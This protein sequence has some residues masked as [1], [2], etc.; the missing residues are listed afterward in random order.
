[1]HDILLF[2][3]NNDNITVSSKIL[4]PPDFRL[5]T[6]SFSESSKMI[7]RNT[8]LIILDMCDV[9]V[10]E[11]PFYRDL[12]NKISRLKKPAIVILN[13]KQSEMIPFIAADLC[14]GS[15]D[16]IFQ[17]QL[18]KELVPRIK[19]VLSRVYDLKENDKTIS[20]DGLVINP[21][22]FELMV[23]GSPVELTFKEYELL[24]FLI[25]NRNR[26]FSRSK[27]LSVIWGYDFYGGSR[28]VDVHMRRLRT[29]LGEPYS[30]MLKTVRNVGY[31][32]APAD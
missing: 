32:F 11:D 1:M 25:E 6:C 3:Q 10:K 5:N 24:K 19:F 28:T 14:V 13:L 9:E 30:N 26:V 31:M 12:F 2:S 18:D 20:I 27:L 8:G 22:K 17:Q 15:G 16:I 4:T 23:D 29:K 7:T 21:E